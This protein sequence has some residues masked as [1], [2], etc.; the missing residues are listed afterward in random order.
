M[1]SRSSLISRL[2]IVNQQQRDL[3][4]N[5]YAA[6]AA[7]VDKNK[8][9]LARLHQYKNDYFESFRLESSGDM[10]S[11]E[12]LVRSRFIKSLEASIISQESVVQ[13]SEQQL[14]SINSRL[15][16]AQVEFR[17][18]E[19][20]SRQ[21]LEKERRESDR[22]EMLAYQELVSVMAGCQQHD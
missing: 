15:M 12:L 3:V 4:A 13:A 8:Q 1:R 10:N 2:N 6:A 22:Q 17:K 20:L 21:Y 11:D 18:Y 14:A 16:S 19:L 9:V 7:T 5:Q